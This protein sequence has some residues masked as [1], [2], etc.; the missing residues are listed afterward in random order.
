MYFHDFIYLAAVA[1][2]LTAEFKGSEVLVRL[3][4]LM[5]DGYMQQSTLPR[6]ICRKQSFIV[7]LLM[8]KEG[9]ERLSASQ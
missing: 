8:M 4:S 9:R 6:G 5:W 3:K 7:T 2:L 1:W